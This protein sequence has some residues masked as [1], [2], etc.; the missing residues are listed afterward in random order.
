VVVG[1][2]VSDAYWYVLWDFG[3]CVCMLVDEFECIFGVVLDGVWVVFG[4]VNLIGEYV[5]Y[6]GGFCLLIVLL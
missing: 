5:D 4:W 3:D 6:N 1:G 2:V